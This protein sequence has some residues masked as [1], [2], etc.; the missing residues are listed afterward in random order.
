MTR[1]PPMTGPPRLPAQLRARAQRTALRL[2]VGGGWIL[3][4]RRAAGGALEP[5]Y[6][7]FL[8]EYG[9]VAFSAVVEFPLPTG[10]PWGKLGVLTELFGRFSDGRG[11]LL[12]E[13]AAAAPVLGPGRLPIGRDLGGN[14]LVLGAGLD[15]VANGGV[16]FWDHEARPTGGGMAPR[17]LV[18]TA[19][20]EQLHRLAPSFAAF[21]AGLT[22]R[23]WDS[24]TRP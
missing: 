10:S 22:G 6:E 11:D 16:W 5:A 21:V 8:L 24:A 2:P 13:L 4:L 1:P 18:V 23:P 15:A 12:A 19:S 14:L 20:G 9:G 17:D 3:Q 7:A